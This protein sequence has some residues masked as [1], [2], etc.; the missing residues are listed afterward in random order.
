MIS[1]VAGTLT[2]G[3]SALGGKGAQIAIGTT[4]DA[5]ESV[6]KQIND[7]K[8]VTFT[9]TASDVVSNKIGGVVAKKLDGALGIKTA[10]RQLSRAERVSA[11]DPT[12]SGRA[13]SVGAAKSSLDAKNGVKQA[14]GG[15]V[16]NTAQST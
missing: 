11:A 7:N 10:E 12:S 16:D 4:I 3:L 14:V 13:N 5:G 9:Q 6:A 15:A 8:G 2:S 1:G